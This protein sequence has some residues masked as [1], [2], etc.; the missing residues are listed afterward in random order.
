[1][2][3]YAPGN[4]IS[5]HCDTHGAFGDAILS[6]TLKADTVMEFLPYDRD[7]ADATDVDAA[8][9]DAAAYADD[10]ADA[11]AA[12]TD[13]AADSDD[14]DEDYVAAID[15]TDVTP[16]CIVLPRRDATDGTRS[17]DKDKTEDRDGGG[18][19]GGNTDSCDAATP[20]PV[21]IVLPRR[22]LLV[23]RGASRYAFTHA[24]APRKTDLINGC[25]C[26]R[27]TRVSL[28]F[29]SVLADRTCRCAFPDHCD[30]TRERS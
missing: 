20:V 11:D 14:K 26:R 15:V 18:G 23:L 13:D 17:A 7:A 22:S 3:R 6:L 4:G 2:N 28:T 9:A 5:H 12:I 25:V 19:G 16:V 30:T 27:G 24:I 21:R 1:V 29:R 10:A 8:D